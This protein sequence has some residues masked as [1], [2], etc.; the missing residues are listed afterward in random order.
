MSVFNSRLEHLYKPVDNQP[1]QN[2]Y[3]ELQQE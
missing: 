3:I 1:E 2:N